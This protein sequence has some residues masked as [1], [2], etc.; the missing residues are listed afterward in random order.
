MYTHTGTLVGYLSTT[1]G[2]SGDIHT[3]SVV[4]SAILFYTY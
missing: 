1:S 4:N 2:D 3:Y